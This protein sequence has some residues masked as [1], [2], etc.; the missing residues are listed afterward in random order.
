MENR[1]LHLPCRDHSNCS[2]LCPKVSKTNVS[3]FNYNIQLTMS[4]LMLKNEKIL[5]EEVS[6]A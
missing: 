3:A 5:D 6:D 4:L 1:F 2:G